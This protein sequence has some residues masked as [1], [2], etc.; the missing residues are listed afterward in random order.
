MSLL[1]DFFSEEYNTQREQW[2]KSLMS[3]LK[4]DQIQ[5]KT[6]KKSLDAGNWPTLSLESSKT[7]HLPV[8]EHWKKA[9][10]T[11][12]HSQLENVE[13]WLNEDL[14]AGVRAFYFYRETLTDGAW[15]KIQE[16]LNKFPKKNEVDVYVIG[17]EKIKTA[18]EVHSDGG[19]NVQELALL[20]TKYIE[21]LEESETTLGIYVDS[22]FFKNIAKIRALKLLIQKINTEAGVS[23]KTKVI[24]L[25][26]FREWTLFERYSNMLRNNAAVASAYIAGADSVQSSGY[27]T[28]LEIETG[29]L[30]KEHNERSRRM[31]RNTSHILA[32]ESMLGIVQDAAYGSYHLESLS[33]QYAQDA[34]EIMQKILPLKGDE[35]KSFIQELTNPVREARMDLVRTRKH[36]LA[37]M[38]DFPDMKEKLLLA[39]TPEAKFFRVA[40]EFEALRLKMEKNTK[41][42]KV[43]IALYG[44]YSALSARINFVKNY[45][46]LLGLEVND[47]SHTKHD[48]D[49]FIKDIHARSEEILVLCAADDQYP[50]IQDKIAEIKN[51]FRFIAGKVEVKGFDPI[52]GGQN[53]YS[54]LEKLVDQWGQK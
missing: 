53:V 6:T 43:H 25:T 34:W 21:S 15:N 24:A 12:V 41:K 33:S 37:G 30:D 44:E 19:N 20:A 8:S 54:V 29:V 35:R 2:E 11:Y 3:E 9:A 49:S 48:M 17:S 5:S 45:F 40:R 47:P 32:L 23:K 28:L 4:L 51:P 16:V 13:E 27:Q 42:P 36:V 50:V 18:F 22:Q 14:E 39:K 7:S 38:N 10:Q 26:S 46:E 1:S 52:F 31:A